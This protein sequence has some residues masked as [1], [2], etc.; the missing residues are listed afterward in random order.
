MENYDEMVP[1]STCPECGKKLDAA[2]DPTDETNR[3]KPGDISVC[4][5]CGSLFAFDFDM[6]LRAVTP[7]EEMEIMDNPE[8]R[9]LILKIKMACLAMRT[10]GL[11]Q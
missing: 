3:P 2:T 11:Q 6:R 4:V 8:L 10:Q 7:E 9:T 1:E 5:Y